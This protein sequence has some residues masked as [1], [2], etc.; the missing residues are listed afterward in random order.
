MTLPAANTQEGLVARLLLSETQTPANATYSDADAQKAMKWMHLVLHNRLKAPTRFGAKTNAGIVDL[1]KAKDQFA[2]FGNYPEMA[3][4]VKTRVDEILKKANDINDTKQ[5]AFRQ[6]VQHALDTAAL[7]VPIADPSP[8]GLTG[9][10]TAGHGPPGG[11]FSPY[12]NPLVGN[13]F[14]QWKTKP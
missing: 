8:N 12:G 13:Q 4:G 1:I 6:H 9:W 11:D 14:Y 10:R 5:S 2:G 7:K 3:A